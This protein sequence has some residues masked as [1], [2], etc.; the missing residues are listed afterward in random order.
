MARLLWYLLV[1]AFV[2]A[3]LVGASYAVAS[4]SIG[5]LLGAPPP[6]MGD[7]TAELLWKGARELPGNP[8]VWK[9][10]FGPTVLPGARSVT[11]Y[12]DPMGKIIE[13]DPKNLPARLK[14]FHD[15]G[16]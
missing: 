2:A 8:R 9:F 11:I 3:L 1:L 4:S 13:T 15:T 5:T 7:Q 6:K 14:L 12:V 16:L 10:S